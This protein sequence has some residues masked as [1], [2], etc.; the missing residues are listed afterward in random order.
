[1]PSDGGGDPVN[2]RRSGRGGDGGG[3]PGRRRDLSAGRRGGRSRG[4]T[5]KRGASVWYAPVLLS[6]FVV[7]E[8]KA[9]AEPSERGR[10]GLA[11]EQRPL[12]SVPTTT[13]RYWI[14]YT[15]CSLCLRPLPRP[16]P[17]NDESPE[18]ITSYR[19]YPSPSAPSYSSPSPFRS[20]TILPFPQF[21]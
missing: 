18:T 14:V 20:P 1:M 17:D 6:V 9:A 7:N 16:C 21:L 2:G 11:R 4:V 3:H 19:A 8:N 10:F 13:Q 15:C 5:V 12:A